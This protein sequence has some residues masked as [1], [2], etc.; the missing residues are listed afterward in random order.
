MVKEQGFIL[1]TYV[2]P[3]QRVEVLTR[4]RGK[5]K[6]QLEM[7]RRQMVLAPGT[8]IAFVITGERFLSAQE[9]EIISVPTVASKREIGWVHHWLELCT[10]F[11]Q[12]DLF[13]ERLFNS[14]RSYCSLLPF[15]IPMFGGNHLGIVASFHLLSQTGFYHDQLFIQ[16]KKMLDTIS[17]LSSYGDFHEILN[18]LEQSVNRLTIKE[19]KQI[20]FFILQSLQKHP[21]FRLF[22]TMRFVYP[23]LTHE[24]LS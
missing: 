20:E 5:L 3:K 10:Y 11:S 18:D 7:P 12:P 6:L 23:R 2:D 16:H 14:L 17:S 21:F 9:L 8:L 22:K 1:Q 24:E 15:S 4:L 13:D 19:I